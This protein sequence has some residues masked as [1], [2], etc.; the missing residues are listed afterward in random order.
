MPFGGLD[1]RAERVNVGTIE[2][3]AN[4]ISDDCESSLGATMMQAAWVKPWFAMVGFGC[5]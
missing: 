3:V 5:S 1:L 4:R 2:T